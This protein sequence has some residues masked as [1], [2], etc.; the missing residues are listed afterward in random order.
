MRWPA[1]YRAALAVG[2][3]PACRLCLAPGFG[4]LALCADCLADLPWLGRT[5]PRCALPLTDGSVCGQCLR[6]P[7]PYSAAWC[8]LAYDYPLHWLIRRFKFAQE[9][10]LLPTLAALMA[11]ALPSATPLDALVPV[12][13]HWRRRVF[14]G[15]N[16]STLL[17][18][19]LARLR[20]IRVMPALRRRVHTVPQLGLSARARRRNLRGAIVRRR[21]V[22]G[23][24]LCLVD[25]V[26]TTGTTLE[27]CARVLRAAGAA[28]VQVVVLARAI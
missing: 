21:G 11:E 13:M 23:L 3:A 5:C 26:M 22:E 4:G 24:R 15:H 17:A 9:L 27:T 16:H 25:D 10:R 18:R 6:R 12:P 28:E 14:R 8:A 20:G 1:V 2:L 19:W 7:P